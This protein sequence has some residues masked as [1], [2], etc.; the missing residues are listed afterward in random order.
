MRGHVGV[1]PPSPVFAGPR[2]NGSKCLDPSV[3]W[4]RPGLAFMGDGAGG[5][6]K[7]G[8]WDGGIVYHQPDDRE[9]QADGMATVLGAREDSVSV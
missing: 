1:R 7:L 8:H 9:P 6:E 3:S 5:T 2:T 4:T